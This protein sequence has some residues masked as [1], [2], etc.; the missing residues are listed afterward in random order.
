MEKGLDVRGMDATEISRKMEK[1][2]ADYFKGYS[3]GEGE[4]MFM[5]GHLFR[6]EEI[7]DMLPKKYLTLFNDGAEFITMSGFINVGEANERVISV[8][9]D[10]QSNYVYLLLMHETDEN[11]EEKGIVIKDFLSGT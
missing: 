6:L 5:E 4:S 1:Y 7:S 9:M 8:V 2:V 3:L 11:G 10:E